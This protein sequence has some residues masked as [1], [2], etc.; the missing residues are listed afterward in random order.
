[1]DKIYKCEQVADRY[2]IK[3]T[4]VW[5]WIRRKQIPAVKIGRNYWIK[6]DDLLAFEERN[7]TI[8]TE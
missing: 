5:A 2:G 3:S 6:E 8:L 4:T 7:R 1:M